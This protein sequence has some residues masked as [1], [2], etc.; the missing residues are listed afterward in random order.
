MITVIL[1]VYKRP[2]TLEKQ[3]EAIKAQTVNIP[4]ENI[5]IWY[6]QSDVT[7]SIKPKNP[8]HKTF[9]CNHNFKFH[10]RFAAAMLAQTEYVAMFD[11]DILPGNNWFKNCLDTMQ[12][13]PGLLGGSGVLLTN[14]VAYNP[15]QKVGWNGLHIKEPTRVDLVG[16]AWFW[17]SEWTKYMWFEKPVTWDN[18]EDIM[19]SYLLQKHGKINTYVPAHPENDKSVWSCDPAFGFKHGND[20]AAS[21]LV[22]Q[23]HNSL[24]DKV[25]E[26]CCDNGWKLV[27]ERL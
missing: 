18:G 11:D 21:W 16:H 20:N 24:R 10:G 7:P 3:I 14:T 13:K 26:E 9:R 2:H 23:N 27:Y 17:K 8:K 15:N 6:N 5:W 4:D 25:V 12:D 22:N 1:N 19:F